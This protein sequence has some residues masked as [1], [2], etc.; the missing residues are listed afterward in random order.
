MPGVSFQS[1]AAGVDHDT[2][3]AAV[4]R[5]RP[6]DFSLFAIAK[7][8][9]AAAALGVGHEVKPLADMG[10]AEARSWGI[11]RPEGVAR[12]FH[13]SLNNVDPSESVV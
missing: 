4:C 10:R 7:S 12:S 6:P 9:P 5:D 8:G 1:R 3:C 11:N 2:N 13:I